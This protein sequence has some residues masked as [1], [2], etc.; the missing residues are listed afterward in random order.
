LINQGLDGAL[1]GPTGDLDPMTGF[2]L[3]WLRQ[4]GFE[5]GPR[6]RAVTLT[7]AAGTG[8]PQL[9]GRGLLAAGTGTSTVCLLS[10]REAVA[11]MP[12]GAGKTAATAD[13]SDHPTIAWE[14]V[15]RLAVCLADAG[16]V[17][18]AQ[19]LRTGP[20]EVA[21]ATCR[22]LVYRMYELFLR[23]GRGRDAAL[24]NALG[25]ALPKLL[26]AARSPVRPP[27]EQ[28]D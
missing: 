13:G 7:A 14:L 21:P 4:Y 8:L 23:R 15:L 3:D 25:T 10:P 26:R 24:L 12:G 2:C 16:P 11:R 28:D 1:H 27:V 9:S 6:S 22:R 19:L 20:G 5:P 18:A 17:A